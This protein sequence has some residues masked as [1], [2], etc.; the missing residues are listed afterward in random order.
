MN[1][2]KPWILTPVLCATAMLMAGGCATF[3]PPPS[4]TPNLNP[5]GNDPLFTLAGID[6]A[7][8]EWEHQ[9]VM[10]VMYTDR[11][12]ELGVGYSIFRL[13][14]PWH[15]FDKALAWGEDGTNIVQGV[16]FRREEPMSFDWR[17]W[18]E[19]VVRTFREDFGME[20]RLLEPKPGYEGYDA[21][22]AGGEGE[23]RAFLAVGYVLRFE[24]DG[25]REKSKTRALEVVVQRVG[26]TIPAPELPFE[27]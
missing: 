27:E 7:M 19:D 10:H 8:A 13:D 25:I 6:S 17:A 20:L 11:C 4:R 16:N 15:G 14:P 22:Y 2:R 26:S 18:A 24:A 3:A 23:W 1:G 5:M 21:Q 12:E 9:S